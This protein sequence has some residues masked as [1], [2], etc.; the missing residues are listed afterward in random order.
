MK[1]S[2]LFI[3]TNI[4]WEQYHDKKSMSEDHI[5]TTTTSK[6]YYTRRD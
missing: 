2:A 4:L 5:T 6:E 3:K 1:L